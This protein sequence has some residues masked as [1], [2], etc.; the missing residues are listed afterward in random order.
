MSML[1]L[2]SGLAEVPYSLAKKRTS[3]VRLV[4][5]GDVL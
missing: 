5:L 1:C 2:H 4:V 3:V